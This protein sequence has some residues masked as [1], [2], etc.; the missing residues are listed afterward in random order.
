MKNMNMATNMHYRIHDL[1]AKSGNIDM[2]PFHK[3]G[4]AFSIRKWRKQRRTSLILRCLSYKNTQRV[5]CGYLD[6]ISAKVIIIIFSY[7]LL[8]ANQTAHLML[9]LSCHFTLSSFIGHTCFAISLIK[10][11]RVMVS[12]PKLFLII[13]LLTLLLVSQLFFRILTIVFAS[14]ISIW[15]VS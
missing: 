6:G 4:S 5:Y 2:Q 8:V 13:S 10:I 12:K 15:P 1:I 7:I 3:I 14:R 11:Q 9:K